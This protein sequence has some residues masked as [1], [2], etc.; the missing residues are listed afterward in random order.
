MQ[1]MCRWSPP[2]FCTTTYLLTYPSRHLFFVASRYAE[3][4]FLS[5]SLF[6]PVTCEEDTNSLERFAYRRKRVKYV[7]FFLFTLLSI[8]PPVYQSSFIY[9]QNLWRSSLLSVFLP[10]NLSLDYHLCYSVPLVYRLTLCG[11][12][13]TSPPSYHRFFFRCGLFT[14]WLSFFFV[15]NVSH[16]ALFILT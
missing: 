11:T 14:G 3:H 13:C 7:P 8:S 6:L 9:L 2:F 15:M 12:Y 5:L 1:N 4:T 16:P 10:I